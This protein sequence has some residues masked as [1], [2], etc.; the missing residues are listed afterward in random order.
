MSQKIQAGGL[1]SA[2]IL[3]WGLI[4]VVAKFGQAGLSSQQFLF[5]SSLV[6]F[7][8]MALLAVVFGVWRSVLS[9]R[10]K[11]WGLV[12]FNGLL[13]TYI[14]YLLLY[15][16][17]AVADGV[18]VLITQ[19]TWPV[20]ICLLSVWLLRETWHRFKTASVLLGC[21]AVVLVLSKGHVTQITVNEPEA[22]LWV[23]VGA[24][25]FAL[26][27]V[28]SK[29]MPYEPISL[30]AIFFLVATVASGLS[31]VT[32]ETL[33]FPVGAERWAV[34]VNGCFVNGISY[35]L[36]VLALRKSDASFIAPFTFAT[37]LVSLL[38]LY[39]FFDERFYPIY[40]LAFGL[41]VLSGFLA[42]YKTAN[43]E[44]A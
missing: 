12:V 39:L 23:L 6:S 33:Q 42:N 27:S 38:Y 36:W 17:Y 2:C 21:M 43:I 41:I 31:M 30:T 10:L 19:Y 9:Y 15:Q 5:W 22:L 35:C 26:F 25:C 32:Q 11:D 14:Y 40:L 24:F 28:L 3:L 44:G 8:V 7:V 20:L 29:K 37:P 1:A 18:E 4:P 16:G 34:L 13:G